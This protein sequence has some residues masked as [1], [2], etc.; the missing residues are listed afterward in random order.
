MECTFAWKSTK[1]LNSLV[2]RQTAR[3]VAGAS[4][5]FRHRVEDSCSNSR[6]FAP[7][8]ALPTKSGAAVMLLSPL[9]D[10]ELRTPATLTASIGEV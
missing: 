6:N 8:N 5:R 7:S 9:G 10:P 4:R 3:A 1:D 2:S